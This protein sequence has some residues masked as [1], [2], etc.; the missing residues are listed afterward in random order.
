MWKLRWQLMAA[1]LL[2]YLYMPLTA[3]TS[4][5]GNRPESIDL[6][7]AIDLLED[8]ASPNVSRAALAEFTHTLLPLQQQR[9]R[10]LAVS[11]QSSDKLESYRCDNSHF[12][13]P[14]VC[15]K[16]ALGIFTADS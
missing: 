10:D 8:D 12:N 7:V 2:L 11:C 6:P 16:F 15:Y 1:L 5:S 9:S 13:H 3:I 4:A 14:F